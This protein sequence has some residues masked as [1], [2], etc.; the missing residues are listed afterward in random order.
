M[1]K[2]ALLAALA[3][4]LVGCTHN[5]DIYVLARSSAD[6]ARTTIAVTVGH[7][8]G[9]FVIQLR[10]KQY[11]G[12]WV[13]VAHGGAVSLGTAIV[14]SG[15]RV[16]TASAMGFSAPTQG[17]GTLFA[18]ASDGSALHC[19]YGFNSWSRSG[20]GVCQDNGGEMFDLQI[21]PA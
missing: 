6:Q 4:V 19:Q 3:A 2:S 7:P 8:S 17:G 18:A 21:N 20:V 10:G 5:Y 11:V 9:E 15:G 14:A 16:A 1:H 13:Y 12:R